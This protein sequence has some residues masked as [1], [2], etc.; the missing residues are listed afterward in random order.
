MGSI[1][2][3]ARA[4]NSKHSALNPGLE[5]IRGLAS[6]EVFLSHLFLVFAF[7]NMPPR[8]R[9]FSGLVIALSQ[10]KNPREAAN[11]CSAIG[12]G[13]L[14][15]GVYLVSAAVLLL[16]APVPY[17]YHNVDLIWLAVPPL[18]ALL[19]G[20]STLINRG[21]F[22]A[23]LPWHNIGLLLGRLSCALY[24]STC[25]SWPW[26][27]TRPTALRLVCFWGW[28]WCFPRRGFL[29]IGCTLTAVQNLTGFG[30]VLPPLARP[31]CSR[32]QPR[33]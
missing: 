26:S 23:Q 29:G 14:V 33:P 22:L 4:E 2:S 6:I 15:A 11:R 25:R 20:V 21:E 5:L 17:P 7:N 18:T 10:R 13:L 32:V 1:Q 30:Q 9:P 28:F 16:S 12:S 24:V 3:E 8:G 19:V 31:A 27:I